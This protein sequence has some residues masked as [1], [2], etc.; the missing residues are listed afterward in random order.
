[1][2]L[3]LLA[4]LITTL[5][6][7]CIE[8][9][10]E[11]WIRADGSGRAEIRYEIPALAA[12]LNGGEKGI[13]QLVNDLLDECPDLTQ[14]DVLVHTEKDR[15]TVRLKLAFPSALDLV[16][17]ARSDVTQ[18]LPTAAQ[19]LLGTLDFQLN[20]RTATVA[21]TL[22]PGKAI[23]GSFFFP[24]SQTNGRALTF[25]AHLPIAATTSNATR[26][27]NLGKTLVW[28][29]PLA[30]ALRQPITTRFEAKLP[31]PWWLTAGTAGLTAFLIWLIITTLRRHKRT[32][33]LSPQPAT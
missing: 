14:R 28:E 30:Q 27:E 2:P 19:H 13:R 9:R 16:D 8:G 24:Q 23:P 7:S 21:R 3:R 29:F 1:M 11:F 22:S 4:F 12:K 18:N 32:P 25:I 10:E 17:L 15:L 33:N 6:A 5:L 20:G 26:T 31:I